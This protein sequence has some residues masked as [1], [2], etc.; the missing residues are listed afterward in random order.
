MSIFV[1]GSTGFLGSYVTHILLQQSKERLAL[2]VRAQ[3]EAQA[4]EKLWRGLQLHTSAQHFHDYLNRIDF[5]FGD[6]HQ[7]QLGIDDSCYKKLTKTAS[8]VLHIA[9]SLNR[10]SAKSCL[11][12]NLRCSLSVIKLAKAISETNGL[13][14]Y[15]HVSTVAVAG[16]RN[17]EVVLED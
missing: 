2:L 5:V 3:D 12:T 1:T 13:R 4:R 8:S 14:R 15:S 17:S 6:L 16:K 10:K 7:P 11:N 9:A